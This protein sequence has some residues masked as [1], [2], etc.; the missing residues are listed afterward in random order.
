LYSGF[1]EKPDEYNCEKLT[2]YYVLKYGSSYISEIYHYLENSKIIESLGNTTINVLSLGCGFCPDYFAISQYIT[3]K[4]LSVQFQYTG[5]EQSSAWNTTRLSF[6]N[7]NCFQADLLKPFSFENIHIIMLNKVFSTIF[8]HGTANTFL[9]NL[10]NAINNSMLLDS[11]LVFNDINH[12]KMGRDFFDTR[13]SQLFS[14][15][16]IR[17]YYTDNPPYTEPA[18]EKIPQ[19][20]VVFPMTALPFIEPINFINR[21]V[22]FEYKK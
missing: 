1:R 14:N 16:K 3:D 9:F 13:I 6:P 20:H 7:A 5:L 19:N 2:N 17:K 8:R 21:N 4:N 22:F 10:S 11:I 12:I 15:Q 18:W